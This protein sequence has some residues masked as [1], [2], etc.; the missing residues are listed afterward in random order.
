MRG[1]A[2]RRP[3]HAHVRVEPCRAGLRAA[4]AARRPRPARTRG[5]PPGRR[6]AAWRRPR[7]TS[8]SCGRRAVHA[9]CPRV[10]R[11]LA[12]TS[13]GARATRR[14]AAH[15]R[16]SS[17]RARG[18]PRRGA[19]RSTRPRRAPRTTPARPPRPGAGRRCPI[20]GSPGGS[21]ARSRGC[22]SPRRGRH[23]S[24][25]RPHDSPRAS[26]RQGA[27]SPFA[28]TTPSGERSSIADTSRRPPSIVDAAARVMSSKDRTAR[29]LPSRPTRR[30]GA[31]RRPVAWPVASRVPERRSRSSPARRDAR[32]RSTRARART[33]TRGA[34]EITSIDPSSASRPSG[35]S[36]VSAGT[37]RRVPSKASRPATVPDSVACGWTR[38]LNGLGPKAP[39]AGVAD[40]VSIERS[41]GP[42]TNERPLISSSTLM[43]SCRTSTRPRRNG[44]TS[45]DA[46]PRPRGRLSVPSACR[47]TAIRGRTSSRRVTST[48]PRNRPR[49]NASRRLSACSR[50]RRPLSSTDVR[51]TSRSSAE[52]P[53]RL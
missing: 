13:V 11:P 53:R 18:R 39:G 17:P 49:P 42:I 15:P 12:P 10:T 26:G 23:R 31:D 20:R 29:P 43:V 4:R 34:G 52:G 45:C 25:A 5:R 47:T 22:R 19:A 8:R 38:R 48:W 16:R 24:S 50:A 14:P 30:A 41:T 32:A 1:R 27:T 40:D 44:V 51:T 46:A 36:I 35:A 6:H 7:S 9:R 37:S 2:R 3:A 33:S 21:A 28:C